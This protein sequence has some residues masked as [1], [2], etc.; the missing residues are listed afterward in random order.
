[1]EN[2]ILRNRFSYTK[3]KCALQ[4]S[5]PSLN[6]LEQQ[7]TSINIKRK[8]FGTVYCR[9][10]WA[11][12][13]MLIRYIWKYKYQLLIL[14]DSVFHLGEREYLVF[15]LLFGLETSLYLV[16]HNLDPSSWQLPNPGCMRNKTSHSWLPWCWVIAW[17]LISLYSDGRMC[18][19]PHFVY[20]DSSQEERNRGYIHS[21]KQHYQR[22]YSEI[23][24]A[25][26][27]STHKIKL[28]S[29]H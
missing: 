18:A 15:D 4:L 12:D 29:H 2:T 9:Q 16:F 5:K 20:Y 13:S 19:S 6:K 3:L 25:L 17:S 26:G 11:I 8:G 27:R 22:I 21:R 28:H 10:G 7:F 24:F 14:L 23:H 1:M